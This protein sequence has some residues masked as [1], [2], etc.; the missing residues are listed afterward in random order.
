ML[1]DEWTH[2]GVGAVVD[3]DGSVFATQIFATKSL[4]LMSTRDRFNQY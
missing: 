1:E 3:A 2:T 4:S